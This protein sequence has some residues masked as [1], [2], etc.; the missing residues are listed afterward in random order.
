MSDQPLAEKAADELGKAGVGVNYWFTNQY[1]FINQWEHLKALKSPFKMAIH[2]LG[3]PQNYA[4]LHL[5][6]TQHSIGRLMSLGIK[7]TWSE[8][9]MDELCATMTRVLTSVLAEH[10]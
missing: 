10:A 5:P 1:H 6:Q 4:N 2:H 3:A 7:V 9:E 8:K